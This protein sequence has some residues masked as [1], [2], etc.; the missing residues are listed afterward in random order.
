VTKLSEGPG[1]R[2]QDS[3]FDLERGESKLSILPD[4]AI[5]VLYSGARDGRYVLGQVKF[6][7]EPGERFE[8]SVPCPV[9]PLGFAQLGQ[10]R[11]WIVRE[12]CAGYPSVW[13]LAEPASANAWRLF[14]GSGDDGVAATTTLGRTLILSQFP[15]T[16]LDSPERDFRTETLLR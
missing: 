13:Q 14:G 11:T 10:R 4:G 2:G 12:Q 15:V 6:S 8:A 1:V 7:A 5:S 9:K 3:R 16:S